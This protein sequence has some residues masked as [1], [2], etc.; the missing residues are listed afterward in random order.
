ME[1][2]EPS[3]LPPTPESA[4]GSA[5]TPEPAP[6]PAK[7]GML[8]ALRRDRYADFAG[9]ATRREF[10]LFVAFVAAAFAGLALLFLACADVDRAVLPEDRLSQLSYKYEVD[11][12]YFSRFETRVVF[13][14]G[15]GTLRTF[16]VAAVAL[17][18]ALLVPGL[19]VTTRRFNDVGH[20]ARWLLL[21]LALPLA[22]RLQPWGDWLWLLLGVVWLGWA[23]W[24]LLRPA[25]VPRAPRRPGAS[26]SGLAG[27]RK[28]GASASAAPA[29]PGG[30]EGHV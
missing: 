20:D 28:T 23:L 15:A 29:A 19:A 3:P 4:P 21:G 7:I 26:R 5:P 30:P 1:T 2:E 9:R 12:R 13:R 17:F 14:V 6:A 25:P 24:N 27:G 18:L 22:L 8:T 11:D 10:W 16:E